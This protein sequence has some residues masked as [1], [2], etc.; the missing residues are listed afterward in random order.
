M[1]VIRLQKYPRFGPVGIPTNK[2][3]LIESLPMDTGQSHLILLWVHMYLMWR[4]VW[5]IG[6]WDQCILCT[7][8]PVCTLLDFMPKFCI[9]LIFWTC[10]IICSHSQQNQ[11]QLLMINTKCYHLQVCNTCIEHDVTVITVV[12]SLCL[13]Y[14]YAVSIYSDCIFETCGISYQQKL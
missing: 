14:H 2:P 7:K 11:L 4:P 6:Q 10:S 1:A 9:I 8:L 3:N 12:Q 13:L 5:V